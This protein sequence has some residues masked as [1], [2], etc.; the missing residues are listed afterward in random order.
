MKNLIFL[1]VLFL[2]TLVYAQGNIDN[3]FCI[4][5]GRL[6]AYESQSDILQLFGPPYSS[7]S[8]LEMKLLDSTIVI[9]SEREYGTAIWKHTL[10]KNVN[11]IGVITDFVD[12]ELP[13]LIR[14]FD[15][16]EPLKYE[17]LFNARIKIINN[18]GSYK[19]FK[20]NTALLAESPRG[21]PYYNDYPMPFKQCLQVLAADNVSIK[22]NTVEC[23]NGSGYLYFIGG[24]LYPDCI[25][26]TETVL[27][28]NYDFMLNRTRQ[29]WQK[30]TSR[31]KDYAKTLSKSAP[32]REKLLQVIDNVSINIKTQQGVEG[33]VL[34]GHNY[35]LG[36]IRDQYGVS[37]CLLKLGYYEEA[38]AILNFYWQIWKQKGVLHNAQGI[39][40]DGFHVHENDQVEI[41][42]YLIVQAFDYLEKSNDQDF[43]R[44]IFPMLEWAWN[45]QKENLEKGMLP[46]NGDETYIACGILPRSAII[47]GS[48]EATLLFLTSGKKLIAWAEKN[49]LWG[50]TTLEENKTILSKTEQ[51]YKQN[52]FENNHIITNNPSRSIGVV[53]PPY[54]HGVCEALG[55]GCEFF[56]WNKKNE[57]NRY[58][59]PVC[60]ATQSLDKTVPQKFYLQSVSLTPL[61]I[62]SDM[63]TNDEIKPMVDEI[64]TRYNQTHTLPS[65][66]DG[67]ISV[68][69]DY[70]FLLY[71]LA[72]LG[73][74]AAGEIYRKMF[75]VLDGVGVWVEYYENNKP[76]GT[77]YRPWESGINLEAAILYAEKFSK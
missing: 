62:G 18:T 31:R 49:K 63:F 36:Y 56:G 22:G 52:F 44:E 28:S 9:T 42:G 27:N 21:I 61:Y 20:L 69:Y 48:A 25:S 46:F 71:N 58:L 6:A 66:P 50:H 41:T 70:G 29:S 57:N 33:S 45:S 68:G 11:T 4:G 8:L 10:V 5:N 30:F 73:N 75:S 12:S 3:I 24:P 40:M 35:H 37:R 51:S 65:R 38:R 67:N 59:C 19:K 7:P 74:P 55:T 53:L 15:I 34:A 13:C 1:V 60:F 47:D 32:E 54:R 39:G 17:L 26:N 64:I 76:M 16:S 77:R 2:Q 23:L 14:K 72:L 43:I